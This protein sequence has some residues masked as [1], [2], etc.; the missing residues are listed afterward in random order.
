MTTGGCFDELDIE[1]ENIKFLRATSL[2]T[3]HEIRLTVVVHIGTGDFEVSE[4]TTGVMS[5]NARALKNGQPIKDLSQWTKTEQT[6][7]LDAKDFYKELR[8]RGYHYTNLFKSVVEVRGDGTS[9]KIKWVD[10]WVRRSIIPIHFNFDSFQLISHFLLS[11]VR[12]FR[13]LSWIACFKSTF[14]H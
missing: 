6:T 14:L 3:S 5:G 13:L 12:F 8:L 4:G 2:T 11:F 10:N 9:G 1:F 7:I